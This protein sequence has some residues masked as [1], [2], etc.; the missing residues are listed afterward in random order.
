MASRKQ[1]SGNTSLFP[2][3]ERK[4][5]LYIWAGKVTPPS[6]SIQ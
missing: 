5:R 3:W 2:D 1:L 4:E 6:S